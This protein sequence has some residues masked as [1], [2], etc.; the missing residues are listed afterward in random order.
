[1]NH[2]LLLGSKSYSRK[3]LLTQA[4]IP[5]TLLEQNA[6]ET[7]CD[8][9]LPLPLLVAQIALLKMGHVIIPDG[10]NE[11]QIC[12]VLT[13]DTMSQDSNGVIHGKPVD[14][15]DAI[16]KIKAAAHGN[17]LCTAFC[18]DKRIWKSGRW[19]LQKRIQEVVAAEYLF[20]IPDQWIDRYLQK[21]IALQTSG[22]IA[23]EEFGV[24]FLKTVQGSYS[25]IVGLP[26]FELRQALEQVDFFT[27]SS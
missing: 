9:K 11:G 7:R 23:I 3:M 15:V 1:M 25:T 18:L 12:F 24:Q 13:A 19:Q 5:F 16:A 10:K 14:R 21:S 2:T 26:M 4:Q 20:I 8:W 27:F 6:D 17:Y 22:A